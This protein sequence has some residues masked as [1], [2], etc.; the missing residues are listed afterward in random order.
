MKKKFTVDFSDRLHGISVIRSDTRMLSAAI[1]VL[2]K[3]RTWLEG[4]LFATSSVNQELSA[5]RRMFRA[6]AAG[7]VNREKAED[8]ARVENIQAFE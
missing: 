6:A 1:T 5:L 2:L 7:F 8:A 4:C 3:Y